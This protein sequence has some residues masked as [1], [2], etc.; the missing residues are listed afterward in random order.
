MLKNISAYKATS[1]YML[2]LLLKKSESGF[3]ASQVAR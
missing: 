3:K 1:L 2:S